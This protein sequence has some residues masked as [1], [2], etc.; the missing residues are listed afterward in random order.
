MIINAAK[1]QD[2]AN[3]LGVE[4]ASLT[5]EILASH[6]RKA[7]KKCHPDSHDDPELWARVSWA[8]ECLERWLQSVPASAVAVVGAAAGS[9]RACAG[10]GRI[11]IAGRGFGKPMTTQCV[12]CN[13][14]GEQPNG[15][16]SPHY[17]RD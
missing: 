2:A 1:A 5:P 16:P 11:P 12:M 17:G 14:S 6:Y 9:C 4:L 10:V 8:K 15:G 3:V 13:G 7:V